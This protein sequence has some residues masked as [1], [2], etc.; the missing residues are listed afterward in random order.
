[1]AF[2]KNLFNQ[3]IEALTLDDAAVEQVAQN[4]QQ[5]LQTGL[6]DVEKSSLSMLKSYVALPTGKETGEYL[7]LDFGGTNVRVLR[8]RLNGGGAF[9]VL[10]KVAKPLRVEG[11]YDYIGAGSKAEQMFDFIAELV[12]EAVEG[13]HQTKFLLGHTFSF[14]STQT[15]LGNARLL[16]WTKEFA[17]AGVEGE[18][19]NDLLLEALHRLG[20]HNV[21]PVAVINDTVAVLLAAAYKQPDTYIGSIYAT[22][23]NTCYLEQFGGHPMV[24]NM[25]SGGF[26]RLTPNAYDEALDKSSEKP[27]LQRLEKMT[28][29][30]YM[31]E[32]FG[33]ML[34]DLLGEKGRKYG[35]TSIDMS[36]IYL[37]ES[38]DLHDVA[39]IIADK[40]GRALDAADCALVRRL[41][42]AII[43]RSARLIAATFAGTVRQLDTEMPVTKQHI[44]VDGSVY[45]KM[46]LA[47]DELERALHTLLAGRAEPVD[48]I[49]ENGGSGLGAAIAACMS[50]A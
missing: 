44:A 30:R 25:E 39:A 26:N 27:G 42:G 12:D 1:M 36:N 6:E 14:P 40:T 23:Q 32:L 45:E 21:E 37:D 49:L 5:D 22:G 3:M 38:E 41:V 43:R 7:A 35:F 46:P 16:C 29:G 19:V 47:K 18:V 8:I 2:D 20:I 17:T 33:L 10:K 28:S 4:F 31:G 24:L 34:A 11:V 50:K 13:D 15:N 48:T 9:D